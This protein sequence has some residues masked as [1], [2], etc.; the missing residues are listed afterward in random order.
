MSLL[1]ICHTQYF[2]DKLSPRI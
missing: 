1:N 2:T